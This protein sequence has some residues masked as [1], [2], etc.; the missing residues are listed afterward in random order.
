MVRTHVKVTICFRVIDRHVLVIGDVYHIEA[1]W[2]IAQ[3]KTNSFSLVEKSTDEEG[4]DESA[5]IFLPPPK[6]TMLEKWVMDLQ[7]RKFLLEQNHLLKQQ[8]T[9][10]RISRCYE[11]LKVRSVIVCASPL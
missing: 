4:E 2:S 1:N 7:K 5:S 10:Q 6:Y 3:V 9:E 8:K 11:H